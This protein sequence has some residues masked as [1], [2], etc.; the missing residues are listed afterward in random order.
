MSDTEKHITHAFEMAREIVWKPERYPDRFIVIPLDPS[1]V[2][3]ILSPERLRL[4]H[5]LRTRGSF[6]SINELADVLHRDQSR[7]SRDL[8]LLVDAGLA[9]TMRHGKAKRVEAD[10]REV[11]L[12]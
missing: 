3:R 6:D 5:T 1:I 12:A 9:R 11:F 7:V 8:D 4:L 10:D 2:G